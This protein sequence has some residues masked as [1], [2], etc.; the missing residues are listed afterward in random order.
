MQTTRLVTKSATMTP[1]ELLIRAEI[2]SAGPIAFARFMELALYAPGVGYYEQPDRAIG[3]TGDFYTSVSVGPMLGFLLAS[4]FAQ[5]A[6]DSTSFQLVEAAAHD[7]R[8]AADIL[9]ALKE[10]HPA[11]WPRVAM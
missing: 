1:A 8:L 10:C 5:W 4:K 7:G 2:E 6:G 9:G 3:R 11:L